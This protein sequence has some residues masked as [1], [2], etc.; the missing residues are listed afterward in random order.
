MIKVTKRG[1]EHM[2][3]KYD[4]EIEKIVSEMNSTENALITTGFSSE[5]WELIRRYIMS[6]LSLHHYVMS[7]IDEG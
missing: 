4:A 1:S 2:M 7:N 6:A 3:G 5:Q